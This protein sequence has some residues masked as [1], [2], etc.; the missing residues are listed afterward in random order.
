MGVRTIT[1]F[2]PQPEVVYVQPTL[3]TGGGG[4]AVS[5]LSVNTARVDPSGNDSTAV[6]GDLGKPFLTVQ[7]AINA[8]QNIGN[9]S[10]PPLIDVGNNVFSEDVT[11]SLTD[12][13]FKGDGSAGGGSGS[14]FNSI[15]F[16][17][18]QTSNLYLLDCL[19]FE[20]TTN[21]TPFTVYAYNAYIAGDVTAAQPSDITIYGYNGSQ[22]QGTVN[23]NADSSLSI[24]DFTSSEN[25]INVGPLGSVS[26]NNVRLNNVG[27]V[28]R[29]LTLSDSR[30]VGTNNAT[31]TTYADV[32]L[33]GI[34]PG[35]TTGQVQAKS[36]NA[37]FDVE[38]INPP[39]GGTVVFSNPG[40]R[41]T[42][43]SGVPVSTTDRTGQGTLYYTPYLH[44]NIYTYSGSAWQAKTFSEISLSLTVTSGKNYDVFIDSGAT[45]L[46]LSTA[47]TNDTT[48]ANALGTQDGV[49][50]LSSDHTKLWLGTIRADGTNTIADSAGGTTTQVGGKRFVWNAYNRVTR[51]ISV[52]DTTPNWSYTTNTIRQA[53]GA[54]GNKVE[55]VTGDASSCITANVIGNVGLATN[56]S[57]GAK[58]GVGVDSTITFSGIVE[59]CFDTA[60]S[61]V[62]S[63]AIGSYMGAPGLGYHYLSW[64]EKGADTISVFTG[65]NGG[66]SS[67]SGMIAWGS[68]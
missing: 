11:T 5:F 51:N 61:T 49:T 47:W 42:T 23:G 20:I 31:T 66:D 7:A 22:F 68:M 14:P 60:S 17:N 18:I 67:Q 57:Y 50:V 45:T 62:F 38:W 65:N 2:L 21:S 35:G 25:Q 28:L 16:T 43:Q 29:S 48:R 52:I 15:T 33:L 1:V 59:L 27:A 24:N 41:L 36:S 40:G 9:F 26:A 37:D 54:S 63:S 46:S 6:V 32:L 30:V 34:G 12:L 3:V 55:Y 64:N 13:A 39:S 44:N 53:N 58:V 8:I 4:G 19:V 10:V 56:A